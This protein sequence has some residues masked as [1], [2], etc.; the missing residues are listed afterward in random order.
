MQ[1]VLN[2]VLDNVP[3]DNQQEQLAAVFDEINEYGF[4]GGYYRLVESDT[5]PTL[6]VLAHDDA[7]GQD[8]RIDQLSRAL[9]QDCIAVYY[10]E[11]KSGAVIGPNAAAWGEFNPKFF[12]TL[13]GQRLAAN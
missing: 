2:I 10:P 12:F 5:E 4:G 3:G 13:S 6:V 8:N 9:R 11:D 7:P 1:I